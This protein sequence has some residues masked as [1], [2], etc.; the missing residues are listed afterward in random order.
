MDGC[1]VIFLIFSG[2]GLNLC[3]LVI[4]YGLQMIKDSNLII[5]AL[6]V[7]ILGLL[8]LFIL[9]GRILLPDALPY[10]EENGKIAVKGRVISVEN[11]PKFTKIIL[12]QEI[13]IVM[14]DR[15]DIGIG[16]NIRVF[17][18]HSRFRNNTEIIA[19]KITLIS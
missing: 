14:F 13:I 16:Q 4:E 17:G 11:N 7:A 2:K 10:K 5:V 3:A 12:S 6:C 1:L 9:S 8:L 15:I 19:E 18:S